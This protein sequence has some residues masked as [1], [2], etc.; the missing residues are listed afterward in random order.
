MS[1][2][3]VASDGPLL[4]DLSPPFSPLPL[5]DGLPEGRR[6][7]CG[8][9]SSA[10]DYKAGF[11]DAGTI[12][13][14][15]PPSTSPGFVLALAG[16]AHGPARSGPV[17]SPALCGMESKILT[18]PTVRGSENHSC[19]KRPQAPLCARSAARGPWPAR[20]ALSSRELH[21]LAKRATTEE[22]CRLWR[23]SSSRSSASC[24]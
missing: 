13:R 19:A 23:W 14:G 20:C 11:C 1:T 2:D 18:H 3:L 17:T 9:I 4:Q 7:A 15:G 6:P 22:T 21:T 10:G 16:D 5:P 8:C 24:L 12:S